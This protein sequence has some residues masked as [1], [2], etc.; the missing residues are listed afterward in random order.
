V[1]PP[2]TTVHL[3]QGD[4][5]TLSVRIRADGPLLDFTGRA[6][7]AEVLDPAGGPG[8][9][10]TITP[11]GVTAALVVPASVTATPGVKTVAI[12]DTVAGNPRT[13]AVLDIHV[14]TRTPAP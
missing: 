5:V 8:T 7:T 3:W 9:P 13:L 11:T 12:V 10:L 6:I 4:H 2:R 14:S 1:T